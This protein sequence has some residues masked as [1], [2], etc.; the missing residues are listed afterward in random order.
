MT[1]TIVFARTD[2][3][4]VSS[5]GA[6]FPLAYNGSG[7][8]K[9]VGS[10]SYWGQRLLS[11]TYSVFEAMAG[12]DLTPVVPS[13]HR[14]TAAYLQFTHA[15]T[16]SPAVARHMAIKGYNWTGAGL[17]AGDYR[18]RTNM[19]ADR[20]YSAVQNAHTVT[21]GKRSHT[22]SDNLLADVQGGASLVALY[23]HS[24][25]SSN[26]SAPTGD[27]TAQVYSGQASG[28]TDDPKLIYTSVERHHLF[29]ILG[30]G[31]TLADGSYASLI[32]DSSAIKLRHV[33][34]TGATTQTYTLPVGTGAVDFAA[35]P[36]GAQGFALA[37]DASDN[38]FVVGISGQSQDNISVLTYAKSPGVYAWTAQPMRVGAIPSYST[39][40]NNVAATWHPTAGGTLVIVVGRT[41]GWAIGGGSGTEMA[42]LMYDSNKLVTAASGSYRATG[43]LLGTIL[44]A[45]A[46]NVPAFNSFGNETGTG[47]DVI[48][49]KANPDWGYVYSFVKSALLGDNEDNPVGRYILNASGT[50]FSHTSY[51]TNATPWGVKDANAKVRTVHT[52]AGQVIAASVDSDSGWGLTLRIYQAS[53][54]TPGLVNLGVVLMDDEAL[55][56]FPVGSNLCTSPAWDL[57]YNATDNQLWIYY[58][59]SATIGRVM[60][61][62]ID[63]NSYQ[64]T[65]ITTQVVNYSATHSVVAL[66]APRNAR[67]SGH[68]WLTIA[69]K[70]TSGGAHSSTV[71]KDLFNVAPTAPTLT[72]RAN[73]DA[74]ASALFAWTFNDPNAGDTQS[75]YYFQIQNVATGT[76]LS[77]TGKVTS[78]TSSRTLTAATLTN[79]NSYRWRVKTWDAADVES[80]WSDYGTFSV[81]AGGTVTITDPVLDNQ[82]GINTDDYLIQWSVSGTT[83]AS[84]RVVL[85]RNDT[86]ATVSDTGY[87]A[88]VATSLLVGGMV[89]DVE[90]TVA[91]TVRNAGLVVSGTGTRLITPTYS[92]PEVPLITVDALPEEGYNLV[93]VENPIP[94]Q[95][96]NNAPEYDFEGSLGATFATSSATFVQDG[97]HAHR[98]TGAAKLT[99]T[100]SPS[101]AYARAPFA[102]VV[103]GVRYTARFWAYS[104]AGDSVTVSIDWQTS[105]GSY[106]STSLAIVSVPA[107][108]W[109]LLTVTAPAPATAGRAIYGPT[110]SGSPG[111]GDAIWV[112]ELSMPEASDRP[113]VTANQVLRRTAGSG[114]PWEV[115][116]TAEP[117]GSFR[118]YSAPAWVAQEYMVRGVA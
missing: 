26:P 76:L 25:R 72:P 78:T 66:R 31:V 41:A 70:A 4:Y 102:V 103:P 85:T 46:P 8:A 117:D 52:G 112:D 54:S 48:A 75:A 77:D 3:G 101:F 114:D 13:T 20:D 2:D 30:A 99:V 111:T 33:D 89:T 108:T 73:F 69:R 61:T 14:V 47:L 107:A 27:E 104:V 10:I 35:D 65:G 38:L 87:I 63:L 60:R 1:T 68:S 105:G 118:D 62:S 56:G 43:S 45:Q 36:A 113:D 109:T 74:T 5:S 64:P 79:G 95:P 116:G 91:V 21:S 40:A 34:N 115:L 51:Q 82:D 98:G 58:V 6:S 93:S 29:P 17:L 59:D 15:N 81:S 22:G 67:T 18:N 92:T 83:Q 9:S 55:S 12:F 80:P 96:A 90:H 49:D 24:N 106:I 94:G 86:G 11:G 19:L 84:Y 28:T 100:G 57:V 88:S 23:L 44:A 110:L 53:G 71:V 37:V 32:W 7:D 97:T 16:L 39:A 42:W 50:G